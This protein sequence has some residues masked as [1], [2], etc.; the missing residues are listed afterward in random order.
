MGGNE[1]FWENK[2]K[3]SAY[4]FYFESF[5]PFS[6]TLIYI[7]ILQFLFYFFTSFSSVGLSIEPRPCTMAQKLSSAIT[8]YYNGQK[9]FGIDFLGYVM[10][11]VISYNI[12]LKQLKNIKTNDMIIEKFDWISNGKKWLFSLASIKYFFP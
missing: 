8:F 3:L 6:R 5:F 10:L 7:C 9:I 4:I 2:N 11:Y 1:K 12:L